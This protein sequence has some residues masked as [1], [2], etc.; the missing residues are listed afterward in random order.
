[1]ME[2]RL[3][4]THASSLF[5]SPIGIFPAEGASGRSVLG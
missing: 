5:S 4:H 3:L 1:M 2:K